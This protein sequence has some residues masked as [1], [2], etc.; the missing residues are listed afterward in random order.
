MRS[1][2]PTLKTAT[3]KRSN[4][5]SKHNIPR[6]YSR[7]HTN[8]NEKTVKTFRVKG[9]SANMREIFLHWQGLQNVHPGDYTVTAHQFAAFSEFGVKAA[10][11][12]LKAALEA[13][14]VERI[15]KPCS[16]AGLAAVYRL[17]DA[18]PRWGFV[19]NQG[20]VANG[21]SPSMDLNNPEKKGPLIPTTDQ[22]PG[23][24]L[25]QPPP[26]GGDVFE[27][28]TEEI[29]TPEY[30]PEDF[31]TP[32]TEVRI[33]KPVVKQGIRHKAKARKEPKPKVE[34]KTAEG[35]ALV[36]LLMSAEV[37]E[38]GAKKAAYLAESQGR[39]RKALENTRL[40]VAWVPSAAWLNSKP[41]YLYS[42]AIGKI[43]EERLRKNL[44]PRRE[45]KQ[46]GGQFVPALG[47]D[48]LKI[49]KAA[50]DDAERAIPLPDSPGHADATHKAGCLKAEYLDLAL[51]ALGSIG[52]SLVTE[53]E[54]QIVQAGIPK[55]DIIFARARKYHL[56]LRVPGL[57]EG[58]P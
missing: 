31:E 2:Q 11:N 46:G 15:L 9:I 45:R 32:E 42:V 53:I 7:T 26:A 6:A 28:V 23:P 30:L 29:T 18:V 49:I 43:S 35:K 37:S 34:P 38:G 48:R 57:V 14:L 22:K 8:F 27:H 58:L 16:R 51:E 33:E 21:F 17:T 50:W 36:S 5:V 47:L 54:G 55:G 1:Y 56:G 20:D 39:I 10:Q 3:V 44:E 52:E 24:K 19:D 41:G 25:L 40:A 4:C 12:A 13:G